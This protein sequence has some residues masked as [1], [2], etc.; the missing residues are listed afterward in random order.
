MARF[1]E[2]DGQLHNPDGSREFIDGGAV[3]GANLYVG[4]KNTESKLEKI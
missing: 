3:G 2:W 4:K 1:N